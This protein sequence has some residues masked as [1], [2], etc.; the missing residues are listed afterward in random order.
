MHGEKLLLVFASWLRRFMTGILPPFAVC[1][2]TQLVLQVLRSRQEGASSPSCPASCFHDCN[3]SVSLWTPTGALKK[4]QWMRAT[5][6]GSSER[7]SSLFLA[8]RRHL[9]AFALLILISGP[10]PFPSPAWS[11][12]TL[13]HLCFFFSGMRL[14][15]TLLMKNSACGYFGVVE[16]QMDG[17][18]SCPFCNRPGV[19]CPF[20]CLLS[21]SLHLCQESAVGKI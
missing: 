21:D 20:A 11:Y 15:K 4:T 8:Q 12:Q 16:L 10:V 1:G 13:F 5:S 9:G 2:R 18:F 3:C 6:E 17:T 7:D 19:F 14:L